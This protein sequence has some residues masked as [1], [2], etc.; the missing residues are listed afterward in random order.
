MKEEVKNIIEKL[1]NTEDI[2]R[3]SQLNNILNNNEEYLNLMNDF[4]N[5]KDS[6]IKNNTYNE[7]IINLRKKL[8]S[9]KELN[10]YLKLQNNLRL[11]SAR[12][13]NIILS[14]IE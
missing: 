12:I 1:D 5:N 10:E 11:L 7:E 8:F 13:N 6:Y 14:V 4:I 9:I 2:K 3:L